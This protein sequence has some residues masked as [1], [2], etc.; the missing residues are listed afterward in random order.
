MEY[1]FDF[2]LGTIMNLI[3]SS[4]GP[5]FQYLIFTQTKGFPG[6]DLGQIILFQGVLLFVLGLKNTIWA[7]LPQYVTRMVRR[8]DLDRLLLKPYSSIGI[9]LASGF[10]PDEFG[11]II[12]GIILM[13]YSVFNLNL[14]L[15]ILNVI[16]FIVFISFGLLL[17]MAMNII[18]TCVVIMLVNIGR[19]NEIMEAFSRFGQYPLD[20][21][22]KILRGVFMTIIPFAIW[23]YIPSKI[24]ISGLNANMLYSLAFCILF[25]ALS[26]KLWGRCLKHYTS[27]GG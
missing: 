22:S 13:V 26:L 14:H 1:R 25:T 3:F 27:G 18:Y 12:A 17:F 15:N 10:S 24:L 2:I 23:V 8:G 19:L 6:W 16:M 9:I 21:Y 5:I 11:A 20:I 7:N 4:V